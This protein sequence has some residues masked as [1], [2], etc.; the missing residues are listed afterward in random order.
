MKLC[1]LSDYHSQHSGLKPTDFEPHD[2]TLFAGDWTGPRNPDKALGATIHFLRWIATL[3]S[4]YQV[5]IAGNH[6]CTPIHH[7]AA[8][9]AE[10]AA[11]PSIIYLENS[12]TTIDNL[13]IYGSPYTPPFFDWHFMASEN[14]LRRMYKSIPSDCNIL[15]THGPTY[16]ILDETDRGVSAGSY[17]LR[18]I[19]PT[20]SQLKLH[21]FGHIHEAYGIQQLDSYTAIN[22]ACLNDRYA[23]EN[24]PIYFT[25]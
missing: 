11:H 4:R 24:S 5:I 22:A 16:G 7:T 19:I 9:Q 23:L 3:P 6:D 25:I 13:V 15:L 1:C 10:L 2:I 20:L 12:S 21:V 18:D 17:A 14:E 8:F